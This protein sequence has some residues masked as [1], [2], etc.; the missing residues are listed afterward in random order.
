MKSIVYIA[1]FLISCGVKTSEYQSESINESVSGKW[2]ITSNRMVREL[3][4]GD[5]P[6][7]GYGSFSALFGATYWSNSNGKIFHL[8]ENGEVSTDITASDF[9]TQIDMRYDIINESLIEFSCKFPK[10]SIRNIMPVH[11]LI[12]DNKMIW[13]I[14]NFLEIKLE[15]E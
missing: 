1:I 11:Y 8:L 12:N 6:E 7:D 10:D 4:K 15:K 14:D 3:E 5:I 9:I 2:T 13:L